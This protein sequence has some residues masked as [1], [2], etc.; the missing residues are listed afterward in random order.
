MELATLFG[1][2]KRRCTK[3]PLRSNAFHAVGKVAKRAIACLDNDDEARRRPG[4]WQRL[5]RLILMHGGTA[6]QV[7]PWR[8]RSVLGA[9]GTNRVE[10]SIFTCM[11]RSS[12]LRASFLAHNTLGSD[13]TSERRMRNRHSV[14]QSLTVP[15]LL[16]LT[17]ELCS[18]I[19][20]FVP[21]WS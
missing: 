8:P 20:L 7:L 11:L 15:R 17:T 16:T 21:R 12:Q 2:G 14:S 4:S 6:S 10:S 13:W 5:Q 9:R 19:S 18:R 3:N 1:L